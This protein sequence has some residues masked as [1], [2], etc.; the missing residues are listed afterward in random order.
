MLGMLQLL[1]ILLFG[2]L[3]PWTKVLLPYVHATFVNISTIWPSECF[4]C[5]FLTIN[6][7]HP[8]LFKFFYR[9]LEF[10]LLFWI[11]MMF[12]P[13]SRYCLPRTSSNFCSLI[14]GH[15]TPAYSFLH[16]LQGLLENWMPTKWDVLCIRRPCRALCPGIEGGAWGLGCPALRPGIH[17]H[18]QWLSSLCFSTVK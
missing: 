2:I 7:F 16:W 14:E 5:I 4:E 8:I 9:Y 6:W 1:S 13:K 17:Q 3:F 12:C 15:L 11:F 18:Q 10:H